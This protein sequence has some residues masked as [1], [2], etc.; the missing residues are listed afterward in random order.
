[1]QKPRLTKEQILFWLHKF[2]GID[3]SKREHRQRLIDTF[4]NAVYLYDDKIVLT[5]NFK[6]GSKTVTMGDV[7]ESYG[8]DL[9]TSSAQTKAAHRAAFVVFQKGEFSGHK[10]Y[11][12]P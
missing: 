12:N 7:E 11:E 10:G 3:I 6:D 5:F 1:M 8:S 4:I 2:R 9:T